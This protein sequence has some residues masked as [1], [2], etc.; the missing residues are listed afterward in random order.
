LYGFHTGFLFEGLR[1]LKAGHRQ[2]KAEDG[3]LGQSGLKAQK[4]AV[5]LNHGAAQA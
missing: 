4:A 2:G 1:A 3:A 5:L